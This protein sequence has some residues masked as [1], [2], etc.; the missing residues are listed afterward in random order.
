MADENNNPTAETPQETGTPPE[1]Q[2]GGKQ[3][4]QDELNA[5]VGDRAKRAEEKARKEL[6]EKLGFKSIKELEDSIA[7]QRKAQENEL[8]ELDKAKARV[9]ELEQTDAQRAQQVNAKLIKAEVR[10]VAGQMGF[11]DLGDAQLADLSEVEIADDGDVK[12]VKEALEALAKAKPYLL[13]GE[14]SKPPA[15][16]TGGGQGNNPASGGAVLTAGEQA[17]VQIAQSRGYAVDPEK[18]AARKAQTRVV[19]NK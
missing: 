16:N 14:P 2:G 19:T 9:T 12:G 7:A 8:S 18:V 11:R 5:I 13:G 6:A 15:P 10:A 3:F 4:T 1:S 17:A